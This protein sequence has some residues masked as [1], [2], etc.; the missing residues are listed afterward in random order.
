MISFKEF[1]LIEIT[2]VG[3]MVSGPD[4]N[5]QGAQPVGFMGNAYGSKRAFFRSRS[6]LRDIFSKRRKS[7]I[8]K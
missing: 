3:N 1:F 7:K 2:N 5:W 6:K 4:I 8:L